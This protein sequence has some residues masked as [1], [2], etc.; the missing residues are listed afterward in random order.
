[1][2]EYGS[3]ARPAQGTWRMKMLRQ[4][5]IS[6]RLWATPPRKVSDGTTG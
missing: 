5:D 1:M 6:A 4:N 3:V 2:L